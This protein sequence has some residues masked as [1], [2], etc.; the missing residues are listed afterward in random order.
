[1]GD[2]EYAP[3]ATGAGLSEFGAAVMVASY[4]S[5]AVAAL[6]RD[7]AMAVAASQDSAVAGAALCDRTWA[8]AALHDSA[9]V[10]AEAGCPATRAGTDRLWLST[11][12]GWMSV[13]DNTGKFFI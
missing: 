12:V 5:A 3:S 11:T 13:D 6:S 8:A 1:M 4:D 9:V 7:S 10:A 2:S